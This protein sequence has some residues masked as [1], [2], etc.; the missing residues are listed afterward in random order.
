M[1]DTTAVLDGQLAL[2]P[3]AD[4]S[5]SQA[6]VY[7]ALSHVTGSAD[8]LDL[9]RV[10]HAHGRNRERNAIGKRLGELEGKGLVMRVGTAVQ[11]GTRR[12]TWRRR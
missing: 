7:E 1:S 12:T 4:L 9:E 2:F 11:G 8:C 10:L 3:P 5:D 6:E